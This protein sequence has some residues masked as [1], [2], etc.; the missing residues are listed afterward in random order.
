MPEVAGG[1]FE[2]AR[3]ADDA[4]AGVV[5]E[6]MPAAVSGP[7]SFGD[8][9]QALASGDLRPSDDRSGA[10]ERPAFSSDLIYKAP[11][12]RSGRRRLKPAR[13]AC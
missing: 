10:G 2:A 8:A 13:S 4:G 12:Y 6:G 1:V 3:F 7:G 11:P 9:R 5:A